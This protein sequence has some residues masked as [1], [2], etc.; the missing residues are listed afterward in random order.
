MRNFYRPILSIPHSRVPKYDF[1]KRIH[2]HLPV[3]VSRCIL[4]LCAAL[5]TQVLFAQARSAQTVPAN[6]TLA[7]GGA[8]ADATKAPKL[9]RFDPNLVDKSLDPCNDFYKYACNKWITA[10]PIPADQ[11]YWT[12]GQ[13]PA[14]VERE[15]AARDARSRQRQRPQPQFRPSEDRRLLRRLHGRKRH[16]RRRPEA[17]AAGTGSHRRA[18]IQERHHAR[19]RPSASPIPRRVAVR[20]QRDQRAAFSASPDNRITTMRPRSSPRLTRAA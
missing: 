20:R 5:S 14:V 11:V 13:R 8:A 12:H 1:P 4:I 16:R 15:P 17:A 2:V 6:S 9:E 19:D 7:G 10:N 3:Y 18:E